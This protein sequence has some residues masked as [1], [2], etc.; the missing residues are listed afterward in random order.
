MH[1]L[2][3]KR[4]V[5]C[6]GVVS[7]SAHKLMTTLMRTMTTTE[8]TDH[9][10]KD[11]IND[12]IFSYLYVSPRVG[13]IVYNVLQ[14]KYD[15]KYLNNVL[16]KLSDIQHNCHRRGLDCHWDYTRLENDLKEIIELKT[17]L[18]Q[19]LQTKLK[20]Q[21]KI[22]SKKRQNKVIS[23]E[24]QQQYNTISDVMKDIY[25]KINVLEEVVIKFVL[26][27]PNDIRNDVKQEYEVISSYE[28]KDKNI[29][30]YKVLNYIQLSYINKCLFNSIIGPKSVYLNTIGTQ[31]NDS[32]IEFFGQSL[33]CNQFVDISGID[34]VKTAVIEATHYKELSDYKSDKLQIN[35]KHKSTHNQ[36][37]NQGLHF[38]GNSSFESICAFISK[39]Q[40]NWT[41]DINAI[42][43][44]SI[45]QEYQQ[46]FTQNNSLN[47]TIITKPDENLSN[48]QMNELNQLLWKCLTQ[49]DIKCR[50]IRT[51]AQQLEISQFSGIDFQVW[52]RSKNQWLTVCQ[53]THYKDYISIRLGAPE[54]H[55]INACLHLYPIII[56]IIEQN[57]TID[58]N[59]EIPQILNKFLI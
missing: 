36:Q 24:L 3:F 31:M 7:G 42:K 34:F 10:L 53:I 58:G 55:I 23:D 30:L 17:Q 59:V 6:I 39:R 44:L 12:R 47:A 28:P 13:H 51:G 48:Y 4:L 11:T 46:C 54:S 1:L 35:A 38:V 25:E 15:N 29:K 8:Y 33:R 27:I 9:Q 20:L 52:L 43:L 56:S 50:S 32:I 21:N 45:G 22:Q 40:F 18:E 49:L 37:L 14:P 41:Q 5:S 26:Q 19:K 2:V 16:H 57:Q